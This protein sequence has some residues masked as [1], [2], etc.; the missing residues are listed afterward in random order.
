MRSFRAEA[1]S[2]FVGQ[3]ISNEPARALST[4]ENIKSNYPIFLTRD[5]KTTRSWLR[6]QARGTER[7]GLVASSGAQRLR[8]EGINIKAEIEP[9]NW[10]LNSCTDVRSSYYLEDV[11]SEFLVQGLELDW[12][13]VCWG[14]GLIIMHR[15]SGTTNPLRVRN[16]NPSMTRHGSYI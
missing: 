3:I 6:S 15:K 7:Y 13:G 16:G 10:F 2:E 14:R 5:I 9:A 12:V 1:L 8:P 11:A 4:Y